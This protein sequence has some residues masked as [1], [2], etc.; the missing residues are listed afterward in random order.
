[1]RQPR[2]WPRG[3]VG[4]LPTQPKCEGGGGCPQALGHP[5]RPSSVGCVSALL[6]Q[7]SQSPLAI[8]CRGCAPAVASAVP[9]TASAKDGSDLW[10]PVRGRP[11]GC[12][13]V[14]RLCI[15]CEVPA[16]FPVGGRVGG[17]GRLHSSCMSPGAHRQNGAS[18][19]RLVGV[20]RRQTGGRGHSTEVL[21]PP[22]LGGSDLWRSGDCRPGVGVA[23]QRSYILR[24]GGS[25][26]WWPGDEQGLV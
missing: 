2:L 11:W 23:S 13:Q 14:Q 9:S 26:L 22:V 18:G 1:M 24:F 10:R 7:R 16:C 20:W 3:K 6:S 5:L 15:L 4:V 19:W 21:R 17:W 8:H 12:A 25:D